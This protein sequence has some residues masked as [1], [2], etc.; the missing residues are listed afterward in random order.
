MEFWYESCPRCKIE[1]ISG[2]QVTIICCNTILG[3][4]QPGAGSIARLFDLQSST[5]PLCYGCPFKAMITKK[6]N[7]SAV[8]YVP[9]TPAQQE[10]CDTCPSW[11]TGGCSSPVSHGSIYCLTGCS[12][13]LLLDWL[14]YWFIARL[15]A[16]LIYSLTG[17][18]TDLL[19]T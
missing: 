10:H 3:R 14:I 2:V 18:S 7:N 6:D 13:N 4:G 9:Q 16:Q 1:N 12:T 8:L 15:A 5:L 17:Y 19:F 11:W